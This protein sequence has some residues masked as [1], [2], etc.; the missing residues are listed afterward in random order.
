MPYSIVHDTKSC[1]ISKPWAI[2]NTKTGDVNGRC[3][4]SHDAALPQH[5]ALMVNVVLKEQRAVVEGL[6]RHSEA[7]APG[8]Q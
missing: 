7:K 8:N 2:K 5:R 1:P 4:E 3:F 6:V